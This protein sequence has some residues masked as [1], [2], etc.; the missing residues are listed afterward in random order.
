MLLSNGC[1]IILCR[2]NGQHHV[3]RRRSEQYSDACVKETADS[4]RLLSLQRLQQMN[5]IF[6]DALTT[7]LV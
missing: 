7:C 1:I 4:E 2:S 3:H 6:C 5:Q